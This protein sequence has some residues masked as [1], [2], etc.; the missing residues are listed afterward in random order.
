M[1]RSTDGHQG[2]SQPLQ[3]QAKAGHDPNPIGKID[4]VAYTYDECFKPLIEVFGEQDLMATRKQAIQEKKLL[5]MTC[6][7][8][9]A[10][11]KVTVLLEFDGRSNP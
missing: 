6:Y 2:R 1:Q 8:Q 10:G 5:T 11:A 3:T 4:D 7:G 9:L